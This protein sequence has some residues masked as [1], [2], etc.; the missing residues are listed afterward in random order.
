M[1]EKMSKHLQNSHSDES[2][3]ACIMAMEKGSKKRRD[4]FVALQ[5]EGDFQHNFKVLEQK[6]GTL[7]PKYRKEKNS[8][9]DDLV[10]CTFCKALYNVKLI[11]VHDEKCP[12]K[13]ST[14]RR[15]RK[16]EAAKQ[17][18]L[19]LPV[20]L[21]VSSGF[22]HRVIAK[23]R[24]DDICRLV[25]NDNLI[26]KYG[27]RLFHRRDIEEH[28]SGLINSRLRELGRLLKVLRERSCMKVSNL[29]AAISATSFDQLVE[30]TKELAVF[31]ENTH[32]FKKGNLAM[33][34]GHALKKSSQIKQSEATKRLGL[35]SDEV[36]QKQIQEAERFD[37]VFSGDWFDSISAT[38]A[39]S[40]GRN[41][42]NKPKLIPSCEELVN[43]CL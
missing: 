37:A 11:A 16:G 40:V 38:A 34:L 43:Y 32:Q 29:N 13:P 36:W 6:S 27:K 15:K 35:G 39:Q 14:E 4:A 1:I 24:S 12:Q 30:A 28:S 10:A 42:M 23:L 8:N 41:R 7:I 21:D 33:R 5:D 17:G 25:K 22:Y 20:P 9:V 3:V 31:D 26:L 18:R 19:M 2:E